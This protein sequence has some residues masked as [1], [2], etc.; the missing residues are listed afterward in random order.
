MADVDTNANVKAAQFLASQEAG[1][2]E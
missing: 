1:N 2:T